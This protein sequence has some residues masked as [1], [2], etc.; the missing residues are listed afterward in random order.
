M[1]LGGGTWT[2]Q[3]KILPGSY[4][5]F[6]STAKASASL[7]MRGIVAMPLF[8]GWGPVG[9]I[10]TVTAEDFQK[11]CLKIFGYFPEA[12]EMLPLRE[13]FRN[14]RILYTYRLTA[15]TAAKAECTF[16]TAKYPGTRG[17]SL[18][19][20][21]AANVD[22]EDAW[23]VSTYL[24]SVCVDKQS[25]W[26]AGQLATNDFVNFK[27]GITLAATA[28]TALTGGTDG[29]A[30]TGAVYQDFLDKIESYRFNTLGCTTDDAT[31]TALFAAFT[32]RLRDDSG[33]KFQA[34]IF[35][36]STEGTEALTVNHE[37]VIAIANKVTG[38]KENIPGIGDY[39][40]IYWTTGAAAS[41]EVNRSNTNKKYDG[42]LEVLAPF[43]QID[44]ELGVRQAWFIFYND[45][46]VVRILEDINTLFTTTEVKGEAFKSNQT[47][48]I[49][50]QIANDIAA[51]FNDRYLGIVPNDAAGRIS[52]WND[53]CKILQ[54]LENIRAI[55]NFDTEL[56]TVEPGENKKAVV[57]NVAAL[58]IVNAMSQLYMSIVIE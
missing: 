42:E 31:T 35:L 6:V 52:L 25:V 33:A 30:I 3:N 44:L 18:K 24:G 48:R 40:L 26:D 4:I 34:V 56:V 36:N 21:I 38:Y 19:I 49:C 43:T 37:G 51:L 13:L 1:A 47:V 29:A 53:V 9:E 27:E 50:D 5:N 23:D 7:S 20:V 39:A 41:C 58:N 22:A 45:N 17:N 57:V 16:A 54:D 46:G 8:L 2:S 10:I 32:K 15:S 14:T 12:D 55:E 11:N 28:G